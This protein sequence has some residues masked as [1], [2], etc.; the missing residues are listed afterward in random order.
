M[1]LVQSHMCI[2]LAMLP[3]H[4]WAELQ[5]E[6]FTVQR[7]P[8]E[9][10]GPK[11][12]EAGA[13]EETGWRIQQKPH[14][15]CCTGYKAGVGPTDS[16]EMG[17]AVATKYANGAKDVWRVFMNN[18]VPAEPGE[19][20]HFCG[21]RKCDPEIRTFWPTR[22]TT[23]MDREAWWRWFDEQLASLPLMSQVVSDRMRAKE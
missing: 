1:G 22:C 5:A 20:E 9:P 6:D 13:K 7:N 4:V 11:P 12:G 16:E 2:H 23:P 3:P 8:K 18:G 19:R 14:S 17:D 21:W 15:S 10:D